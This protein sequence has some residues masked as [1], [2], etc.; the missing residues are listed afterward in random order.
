MAKKATRHYDDETETEEAGATFKSLEELKN[1]GVNVLAEAR[2]HGMHSALILGDSSNRIWVLPSQDSLTVP[3]GTILGS[4][5]SGKVRE[6]PLGATTA[7]HHVPFGLP[8]GD[9]T[10][11]ILSKKSGKDDASD[12]VGSKVPETLY[13]VTKALMKANQ[14]AAVKLAGVDTL[15]PVTS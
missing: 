1:S 5:G 14:G 11:I 2:M 15:K 13:K 8:L 12:D 9:R 6:V 3:K 10:P 4:Y 7:G